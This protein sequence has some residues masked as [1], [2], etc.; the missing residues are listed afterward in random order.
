MLARSAGLV[1]TRA[2]ALVQ[3][4][5]ADAWVEGQGAEIELHQGEEPKW[6]PGQT[7]IHGGNNVGP[8]RTVIVCI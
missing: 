4:T 1:R 8:F 6:A 3:L 2:D 7:Y 5:R